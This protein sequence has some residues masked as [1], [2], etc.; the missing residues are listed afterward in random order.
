[1]FSLNFGEFMHAIHICAISQMNQWK[2]LIA[3]RSERTHPLVNDGPRGGNFICELL[4]LFI[5]SQSRAGNKLC[6][7]SGHNHAL[8]SLMAR[9]PHR[10]SFLIWWTTRVQYIWTAKIALTPKPDLHTL[11]AFL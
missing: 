4:A 3:T 8:L 6:T 9:N 7:S 1:M 2:E 11:P 5:P 10:A